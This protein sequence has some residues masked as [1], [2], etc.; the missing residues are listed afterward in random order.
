[1]M[2]KVMQQKGVASLPQLIEDA[3]RQGVRLIA[4]TMSMEIM[5]IRAEE[6]IDGLDYA[7]VGAYIGAAENARMNL[8]I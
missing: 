7:G 3:K 2:K 6:L 1:M 4:C 8:F 5:G